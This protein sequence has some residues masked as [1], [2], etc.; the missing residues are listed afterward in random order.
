[1]RETY[2][3]SLIALALISV[4]LLEYSKSVCE[5]FD[6]GGILSI[7]ILRG[8]EETTEQIFSKGYRDRAIWA[9]MAVK[10]IPISALFYF[11][12][13]SSWL[14]PIALAFGVLLA[15]TVAM[16]RVLVIRNGT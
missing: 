14:N 9:L 3:A 6:I 13:R 7:S 8:V 2:I 4:I 11:L 5:S 10:Y 16:V 12:V 1:L 15:H